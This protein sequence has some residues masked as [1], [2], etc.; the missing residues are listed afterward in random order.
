[1]KDKITL[2]DIIKRYRP[3]EVDFVF[4]RVEGDTPVYLDLY[5]LYHSP[6]KRWN[7]VQVI[8]FEYFNHLLKLYKDNKIS[9]VLLI[10]SLYFPEVPYLAL[11]HCKN[12]IHGFGSASERAN[13]IKENIFDNEDIKVFGLEQLANMSITMGGFGPDL[14][15]DMISN[16][17]MNQLLDYT[18]EQVELYNLDTIEVQID[19]KLNLST[20]EW[21]PELKA[22]LPYFKSSQEP[23]ILVPKH[24]VKRMPIYSTTGFYD[25][26]LQ[27]ILQEEK[28][29][30]DRMLKTLVKPRKVTLLEIEQDLKDKYGTVGEAAKTLGL[31]R[32]DTIKEYI[33][34]P[35]IYKKKS[36]IR[37]KDKIDTEKYINEIKSI[38]KG[39][40]G[41]KTYA[42]TIRKIFSVLYGDKFVNGTIETKSVDGIFRYDIN[43]ANSA[44]TVLFKCIRNNQIKSGLV[45]F[46]VKNYDKTELSNKEFNQ[47]NGYGILGGRELVFLVTRDPVTDAHI[48]K[49]RRYFLTH[50]ILI[51][52]IS[53]QD[54]INLLNERNKSLDNFDYDLTVRVQKIMRA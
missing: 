37:K 26:Y 31:R 19:R 22:K 14:A 38:P 4:P 11:G 27:Y 54:I 52:P 28:S 34:K 17:G 45:I 3:N 7:H 15:S 25:N 1:M 47:A 40:E 18:K 2:D 48:E 8:M 29:D 12:G 21:E 44:D 23:R 9:D 6:D 35:L 20:L 42:E 16:F 33:N 39:N 30:K 51:L 13:L 32:P 10:N 36:G 24:L 5:Y 41:A 49:S 46:E 53:D 50:K 43:F